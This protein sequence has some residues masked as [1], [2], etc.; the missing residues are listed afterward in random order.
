LLNVNSANV[1]SRDDPHVINATLWP[2]I[3]RNSEIF[4]MS[5]TVG[6]KAV[7]QVKRMSFEISLSV[8]RILMEPNP[9]QY[10]DNNTYRLIPVLD[11][12]RV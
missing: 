4:T 7:V 3:P 11:L 6:N 12:N 8:L 2:T 5:A 1:V 9:L 10:G